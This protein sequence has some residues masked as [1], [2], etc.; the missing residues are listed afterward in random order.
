MTANDEDPNSG[1]FRDRLRSRLGRAAE[2]ARPTVESATEATKEWREVAAER[3]K[4]AAEAAQE[5]VDRGYRTVTLR[6]YRD[7]IDGMLADVTE[8]LTV[9]DARVRALEARVEELRVE[10]ESDGDDSS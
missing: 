1:T 7:E 10:K 8:V 3:T 4:D 6:E 2:A 5:R 9:L